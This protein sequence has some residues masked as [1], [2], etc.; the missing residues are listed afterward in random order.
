MQPDFFNG[1]NSQKTGFEIL[2]Q[3]YKF[4]NNGKVFYYWRTAE[5][6]A[7]ASAPA[8]APAPAPTSA[9]SSS[10]TIITVKNSYVKYIQYTLNCQAS[11]IGLTQKLAI[12]G[13]YGPKVSSAISTFQRKKSQ[14]FIDGVVDSETKS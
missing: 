5:Q 6:I 7:A 2:V 8:P 14:S 10:N 11:L 13:E 3:V 12:D 9:S 4:V 1:I